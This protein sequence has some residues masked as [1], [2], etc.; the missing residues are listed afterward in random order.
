V[1]FPQTLQL[2]ALVAQPLQHVEFSLDRGG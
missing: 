2:R 1:L